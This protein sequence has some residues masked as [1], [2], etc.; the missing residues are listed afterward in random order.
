MNTNSKRI[1]T[2]G[3]ELNTIED[4]TRA[5]DPCGFYFGV[6]CKQLG[7]TQTDPWKIQQ[8]VAQSMSLAAEMFVEGF[9]KRNGHCGLAFNPHEDDAIIFVQDWRGRIAKFEI[10]IK[11]K[12][13]YTARRINE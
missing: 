5:S 13:V 2:S 12:K 4:E 6:W 8:I 11:M 1:T 3:T 10:T 9:D 7:F